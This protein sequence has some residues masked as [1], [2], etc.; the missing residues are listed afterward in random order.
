[1]LLE[2][3]IK[4]LSSEEMSLLEKAKT[5]EDVEK[6]I[7]EINLEL[8]DEEKTS[9]ISLV[10]NEGPCELSDDEIT[11]AT[12]GTEANAWFDC[13]NGPGKHWENTFIA[14]FSGVATNPLIKCKSHNCSQ[15]AEEDQGHNHR[16]NY[17]CGYFNRT[18][19]YMPPPMMYV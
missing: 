1:M 13:C 7:S 17:Y 14:H 3:K 16:W 2:D 8:S 4:Q 10:E 9:L 6:V 11:Q 5:A 15:Y 12:G 18:V 19:Y